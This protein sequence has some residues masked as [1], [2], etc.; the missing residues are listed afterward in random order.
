MSFYYP[1]RFKQQYL[2]YLAGLKAAGV[3]LSIG[4][5]HHAQHHYYE[6]ADLERANDLLAAAGLRDADFWW[7]PAGR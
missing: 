1:E 6:Q 7:L 2:D 5:D 3:A 4:S